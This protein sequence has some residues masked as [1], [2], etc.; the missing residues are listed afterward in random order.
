MANVNVVESFGDFGT[1]F[2]SSKK[3]QIGN[4]KIF[5]NG[6]HKVSMREDVAALRKADS[7]KSI[8]SFGSMQNDH[9]PDGVGSA[10]VEVHAGKKRESTPE[11][12]LA[13][14]ENGLFELIDDIFMASES[15]IDILNDLL[16][17]E[18]ID[19]GQSPS[20]TY[21]PFSSLI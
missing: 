4:G 2:G 7:T 20:S 1:S 19:A 14:V 16:N 12:R 10:V 13:R 15:A 8:D 3:H 6:S 5:I 18:H 21:R 17:Y 9:V 11:E